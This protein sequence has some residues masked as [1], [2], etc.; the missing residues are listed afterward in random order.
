MKK[1]SFGILTIA[2]LALAG[3]DNN[4]GGTS[5]QYNSTSGTSSSTNLTPTP[6]PNSPRDG[7][8]SPGSINTPASTNSVPP[9]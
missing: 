6:T 9:N 7:A 5:D 2:A 4:K 8:T 1:L 3:C